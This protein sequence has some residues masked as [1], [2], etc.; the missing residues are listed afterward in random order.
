MA[1]PTPPTSIERPLPQTA[2]KSVV[3][4]SLTTTKT[5]D[6]RRS[7]DI[8]F[9]PTTRNDHVAH[10]QTGRAVKWG[11]LSVDVYQVQGSLPGSLPIHNNACFSIDGFPLREDKIR[12]QGELA[13]S[14]LPRV[15]W[16]DSNHQ[17]HALKYQY[18]ILLSHRDH[19]SGRLI[20]GGRRRW[21]LRHSLQVPRHAR[22][23]HLR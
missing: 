14:G 7:H 11:L 13:S 12:H 1:Y 2:K 5:A 17:S 6:R 3:T 9:Q 8:S 19:R 15:K 22:H 20:N 4:Y 23:R 18:A 16:S 21:L 10:P